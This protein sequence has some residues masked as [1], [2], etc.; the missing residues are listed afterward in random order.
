MILQQLSKCLFLRQRISRL[1][2][3]QIRA[4]YLINIALA[5]A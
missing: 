2:E 5:I 3:V 1:R 4:T